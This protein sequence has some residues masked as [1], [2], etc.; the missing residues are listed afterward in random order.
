MKDFWQ[1]VNDPQMPTLAD[2]TPQQVIGAIRAFMTGVWDNM[3]LSSN[4]IITAIKDEYGDELLEILLR[5]SEDAIQEA[6]AL[7]MKSYPDAQCSDPDADNYVWIDTHNNVLVTDMGKTIF[8][9]NLFD[10]IGEQ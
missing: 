9:G 5:E 7:A 1:P 3:C 10:R 2:Y 8:V 6:M 4:W